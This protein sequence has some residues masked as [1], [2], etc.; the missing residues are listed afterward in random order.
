MLTKLFI[1]FFLFFNSMLS[2]PIVWFITNMTFFLLKSCFLVSFITLIS[3]I[4]IFSSLPIISPSTL[5]NNGW[6]LLNPPY[7]STNTKNNDN[8]DV[9][10][11]SFNES[12]FDNGRNVIIVATIILST[13]LYSY[14]Y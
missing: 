7:V 14:Y 12:K 6:S 3:L 13:I 5:P 8:A 2:R 1:Y 9:V 10:P 11:I 4:Y